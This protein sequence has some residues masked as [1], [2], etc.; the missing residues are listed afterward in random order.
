MLF[1]FNAAQKYELEYWRQWV[2]GEHSSIQSFQK[3]L[4]EFNHALDKKL[5]YPGPRNQIAKFF[6]PEDWMIFAKYLEPRT[7]LEIGCA[8]EGMVP[9]WYWVKERHLLDPLIDEYRKLVDPA[10]EKQ[11]MHSWFTGS[12]NYSVRAEEHIYSEKITGA[13]VCR[14]MLD[15][16]DRPFEA[17]E[18]MLEYGATGCYFLFWS[19]IWHNNPTDEG[20]RNITR[21]PAVIRECIQ[22]HGYKITKEFSDVW[23]G[24]GDTI[25]YGC[26]GIKLR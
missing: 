4:E 20:H 22:N 21:D 18:T 11:Q 12:W 6:N 26:L 15:H 3:T 17:L 19:D 10:A 5:L 23:E 24:R 13:I 16:C 8:A 14:N 9:F 7:C 1:D 25:E 2:A